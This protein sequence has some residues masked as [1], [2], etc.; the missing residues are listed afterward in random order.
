MKGVRSFPSSF[1]LG[2]TLRDSGKDLIVKTFQRPKLSSCIY[3]RSLNPPPAPATM[4]LRHQAVALGFSRTI[5]SHHCF[6]QSIF[7]IS[8]SLPKWSHTARMLK[9]WKFYMKPNPSKE[10]TANS[11]C[12]TLQTSTISETDCSRSSFC[13]A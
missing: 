8:I 7:I 4:G 12:T 2:F 3:P 5:L 10:M 1:P 9:G 6:L 11:L 13:E